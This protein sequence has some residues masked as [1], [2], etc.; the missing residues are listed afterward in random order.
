MYINS[1]LHVTGI[2]AS[3]CWNIRR[4]LILCYTCI[5][6]LLCSSTPSFLSRLWQDNW[7]SSVSVTQSR[8][9]CDCSVTHTPSYLLH[10]AEEVLLDYVKYNGTVYTHIEVPTTAHIDIHSAGCTQECLWTGTQFTASLHSTS[11]FSFPALDL[12]LFGFELLNNIKH[13][14]LQR[15]ND[16]RW[17]VCL[18]CVLRFQSRFWCEVAV[19]SPNVLC[20]FWDIR[21]NVSK[22][23][24]CLPFRITG[25]MWM[26]SICTTEISLS[27]FTQET[28]QKDKKTLVYF[29]GELLSNTSPCRIW[30]CSC[31]LCQI[32]E[33]WPEHAGV[34]A[35]RLTEFL[36]LYLQAQKSWIE[37]AFSKRECVHIIVS[38]KDPHRWVRICVKEEILMHYIIVFE[39]EWHNA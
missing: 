23:M 31:C 30:A 32:M 36:C 13:F 19:F 15:L 24:L 27:H 22:C 38:A 8:S 11:A 2:H 4:L 35:P 1:C 5:S 26:K 39:C 3:I 14:C 21:S 18:L 12:I 37:R 16:V 6:G 7:L 33:L 29:T 10:Y 9:R 34:T 20:N 28:E 25:E 17:S